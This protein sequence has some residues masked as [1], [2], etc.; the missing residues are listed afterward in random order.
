MQPDALQNLNSRTV[1][2]RFRTTAILGMLGLMVVLAGC[3]GVA[4]ELPFAAPE[5]YT[6][7][8][9]D[10]NG[11]LLSSD[12]LAGLEDAESFSSRS[13]LV[14]DSKEHT[15]EVNHTAAVDSSSDRLLRSSQ[16]N[17]DIVEGEGLVVTSYTNGSL[18]HR[19][20]KIDAGQQ[21]VSRYDTARGPYDNRPL[22]IQPVD[23]SEAAHADL[24][25]SVADDV[26]WTMVGVERYDN[27]WV[28]R[29]EARGAKNFSTVDTTMLAEGESTAT[30]R[31]RLPET[32]DLDIQAINATLLVSPDGVVRLVKIQATGIS[33]GHPVELKLTMSTDDIGNTRVEAPPWIDEAQAK[34]S[35]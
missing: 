29:Y 28:T 26:N 8:G 25:T 6:Q 19:Q 7:T 10:L 32:L 18:T 16:Y 31:A 23:V 17:S 15:V 1:L 30:D 4:A 34:S 22:A 14:V 20:V 3:A 27:S 21:T 33:A 12:H 24:V 2:R 11:S 35:V 5:P 9:A 13:T